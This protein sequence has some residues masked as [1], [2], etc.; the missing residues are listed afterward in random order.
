MDRDSELLSVRRTARRL[1]VH[2]NTVRAYAKQG[3]LADARVPGTS[4]Y[5]FRAS[6]VDRLTVQRGAPTVSLAFER[7]TASPE[8]AAASQLALWP[9]TSAREAQDR[10]PEFVRRLLFETPGAGQISIRTRDGVALAGKDGVATLE[11]QTQL[12]PAGQIWF[13]FGTD[14]DSKRKATK[15]YDGRKGEASQDVTFVFVTVRRWQGKDTWAAERRAQQVFK[16][17]LVLDA[18]DLE[19]W[20]QV[21][22]AAHLWI[23]ETLGLRPRDALTLETWWDRFS[24]ATEPALP[25]KLFIAGRAKEAQRLRALLGE[26]PRI[27]SI[28][29]ESVDDALGFLHACL[30]PDESNPSG[31]A[32]VTIVRSTDVWD[33]VAA[34][35][36]PGSSCPTSTTQT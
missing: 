1:G 20:L 24:A 26:E 17:V 11:R 28:Q 9:E 33:R 15:D 10:L 35:P 13:E 36:G 30:T 31:P 25:L 14:K 27:T 18:D 8:Y 19:P 3:L 34:L 2:E 23:S 6:D 16:D 29:A 5:K 32:A 7:R 4:F 22:P 21:A 12:L